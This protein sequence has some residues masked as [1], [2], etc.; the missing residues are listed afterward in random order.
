MKKLRFL[1]AILISGLCWFFSCD[2]SGNYWYLLW[3]APVPV[4]LLSFHACARNAFII[5]FIAYLIGRLSW[6]SYLLLILPMPLAI[7]S[8]GLLPL[9]FALIVL[10]TRKIVLTKQHAWSVFAFPVLWCLF[11]FLVFKFSPDGTAGSLA[12]TQSN[13]LQVI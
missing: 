5:S 7:F 4:L 3:I 6:L 1:A 2:L 11:E 8:T 9:I 13:F 12:Y 10:L